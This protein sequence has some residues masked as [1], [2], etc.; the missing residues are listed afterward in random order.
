MRHEL[1]REL[2]RRKNAFSVEAAIARRERRLLEALL[3]EPE[4]IARHV[5]LV[6]TLG[7]ERGRM[8]R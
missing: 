2:L 6:S 7:P 1:T 5:W 4:R 3:S 8:W